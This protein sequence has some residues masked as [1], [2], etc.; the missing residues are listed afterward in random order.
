MGT[1]LIHGRDLALPAAF[2]IAAAVAVLYAVGFDQGPLAA[3]FSGA[4]SESGG[5]LH[6]MFHDARHLLGAPCH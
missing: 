3:L 4:M 2:V 1:D 5:V 6:D